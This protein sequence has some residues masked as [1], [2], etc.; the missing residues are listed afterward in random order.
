[1]GT[2]LS[3]SFNIVVFSLVAL[4]GVVPAAGAEEMT[5]SATFQE[6]SGQ[7]STIEVTVT[8]AEPATPPAPPVIETPETSAVPE[9]STLVL[10]G[11]GVLGWWG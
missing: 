4:V 2:V 6:P 9:P 7:T 8:L 5:L 1:M 11:L 3:H 10:L